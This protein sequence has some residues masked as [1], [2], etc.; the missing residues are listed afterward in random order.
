MKQCPV[1]K[2][3]YSDDTLVFC[4][5][6]GANL[7]STPDSPAATE[8]MTFEPWR[9]EISQ[10]QSE[11]TII[12]APAARSKKSKG[13]IYGLLAVILLLLIGV[14]AIA[15][16][17][18]YRNSV[19]TQISSNNSPSPSVSVTPL[20]S[21]DNTQELKQRLANVEKQLSEQKNAKINSTPLPAPAQSN[22]SPPA[23]ITAR[24][25]PTSDGFLALRSAPSAESGEQILKIPTGA[26]VQL[27]DC[28]RNYVNIGG[29][30]GRWCM[31]SYG[32][33]TGW[34]FNAFL[35]Y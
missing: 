15:A 25:V 33:E 7:V 9:V 29:R 32:G 19:K 10:N 13:L 35:S 22:L 26:T 8:Q 18:F 21:A 16:F 5:N 12:S 2:T 28:Q 34:A 11:P 23:A 6:D 1:C 31:I 14:G 24:V 30:R 17:L 20:K 27:E 3:A 4:L